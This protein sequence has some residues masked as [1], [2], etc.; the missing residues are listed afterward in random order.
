AGGVGIAGCVT[1]TD[2]SILAITAFVLFQRFLQLLAHFK[3]V[4]QR[5]KMSGRE[6]LHF[7]V[8]CVV[9][10]IFKEVDGVLMCVHGHF[11]GVF[12]IKARTV[13]LAQF[14]NQFAL[15]AFQ[16]N[17]QLEAFLFR[18][19]LQ[20]LVHGGVVLDHHFGVTLQDRKSVV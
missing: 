10:R 2:G 3:V 5:G 1:R 11:F 20:L 6:G 15:A 12:F 18:Q 14:F 4:L 17:R 9:R 16:F 8:V 13:F 7:G 19:G